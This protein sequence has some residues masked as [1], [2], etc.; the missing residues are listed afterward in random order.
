MWILGV[1]ERDV[2]FR[3]GSV[4]R[5]AKKHGIEMD[6]TP[7]QSNPWRDPREKRFPSRH[8]IVRFMKGGKEFTTAF[9]MGFGIASPPTLTMVLISSAHDALSLESNKRDFLEYADSYGLDPSDTWQQRHF[10]DFLEHMDQF[11]A[12]LGPEAYNELL[13]K[14]PEVQDR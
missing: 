10:L 14:V 3:A 5:F 12:F 13:Y 11:R 4:G 6:F 7:V 2:T 1:R 8:Y 9:S